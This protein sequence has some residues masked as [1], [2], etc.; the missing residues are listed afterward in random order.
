MQTQC[1]SNQLEFEGFD[2]A[3]L[4]REASASATRC[5]ARD[6]SGYCSGDLEAVRQAAAMTG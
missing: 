5:Y 4:D 6:D 2:D 3:A 1:I